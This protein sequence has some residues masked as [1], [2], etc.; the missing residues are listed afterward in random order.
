MAAITH[1]LRPSPAWRAPDG[2]PAATAV[3]AALPAPDSDAV[4]VLLSRD[5]SRLRGFR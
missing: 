5:Y 2:A 3:A 1:T 4:P